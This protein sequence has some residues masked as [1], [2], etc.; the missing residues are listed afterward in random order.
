M[1]KSSAKRLVHLKGTRLV[2]WFQ[3]QTKLTSPST[4]SNE[5][6]ILLI[7]QLLAF[8]FFSFN[9]PF[10]LWQTICRAPQRPE[11]WNCSHLQCSQKTSKQKPTTKKP[12]GTEQNIPNGC[13]LSSSSVWFT[14][15]LHVQWAKQGGCLLQLQC[16]L[17]GKLQCY[18]Y[19]QSSHTCN[20][21]DTSGK[22]WSTAQVWHDCVPCPTSPCF[23]H[24]GLHKVL[25]SPICK[26]LQVC[27]GKPDI[28][29]S[30][31]TKTE[32]KIDSE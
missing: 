11:L 23:T 17:F 9:T 4:A 24:H 21:A 20:R 28:Q 10:Q 13:Q 29:K 22:Y 31:L 12:K 8:T 27:M 18:M 19:V 16:W 7:L 2:L 25:K 3:G 26:L 30:T 14:E 1:H 5:E 6:S 15:Q 32:R